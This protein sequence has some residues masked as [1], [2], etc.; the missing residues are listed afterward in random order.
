MIYNGKIWIG[1]A[2]GEK[3]CIEPKMANRHGLIAG[4]TGTG[5]TITLKVLAESF[6]D[7]GVP[8]FLA[9]IKGD[10]SGMCRPGVDSEDMQKR[11]SKFGLE[12]CG[13]RYQSYPSV[14][15]DIYGKMGIPARTTI[16]EMEPVLL[17][18][19]LWDNDRIIMVSDGVLESLP[20]EKKE[21]SMREFLDGMGAGN[22][23]EMAE[24]I[25]QFALSVSGE[26][27]DDMT[28]LVGGIFER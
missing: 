11:I 18:R 25:L 22:P 26:P 28:V 1:D 24:R 14:F 12:E 3:V 2:A 27:E 7:A 5:K 9:D 21:E 16:S 8:V 23:Q 15:W 13:F 17:S 19:K 6:S 4:A 20:G 10:L